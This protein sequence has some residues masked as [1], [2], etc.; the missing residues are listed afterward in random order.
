LIAQRCNGGVIEAIQDK[1]FGY[2]QDRTFLRSLVYSGGLDVAID[3]LNEV[4]P[5][6]RAQV[7]SFIERYFRANVIVS[8][9]P[10]EWTPPK[11]AMV[12]ALQPLTPEQIRAFLL[13]RETILPK[14]AVHRGSEYELACNSYLAGIFNSK[15][16][17]NAKENTLRML[18]NPMDLTV[19]AIMLSRGEQPDLF[20]LREQQYRIMA[21]DY[22][23]TNLDQDFPLRAF[24]EHCYQL[25][26][27]D[28]LAISAQQFQKELLCMERHKLVVTRQPK[29]PDEKPNIEWLFRHDK[30]M[31]F[32]IAQTFLGQGNERP[33]QHIGDARFRGVFLLLATFL[34]LDAAT[35]LRERLVDYAADTKDHTVSDTFV[36]LLRGRKAA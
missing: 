31:E 24:S 28:E 36:Q 14:D 29:D 26:L 13:S 9:Q 4:S 27:H 34:P 1:L 35:A 3:G 7:N 10:L 19:V 11:T 33:Q 15:P 21:D 20:R 22:K 23:R 2:A 32:F 16:A 30:I 6:T 5:D 17:N 12:Y 25:R 18:S 8:T